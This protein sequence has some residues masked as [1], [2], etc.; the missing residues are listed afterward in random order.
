MAI[1]V[2]YDSNDETSHYITL[3]VDDSENDKE[4]DQFLMELLSDF[5]FGNERTEQIFKRR[6][7]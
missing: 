7:G 6:A 1:R 5:F 2:S 4:N 3:A